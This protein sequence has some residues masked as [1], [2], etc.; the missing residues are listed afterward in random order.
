MYP[1]LKH[2]VLPQIPIWEL[3]SQQDYVGPLRG[4]EHQ[5]IAVPSVCV[6]LQ[7]QTTCKL[8]VLATARFLPRAETGADG[9]I[10]EE[11]QPVQETQVALN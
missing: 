7:S 1:F 2:S 5:S 4:S 6:G 8:Q 9:F 11:T 10:F 3:R